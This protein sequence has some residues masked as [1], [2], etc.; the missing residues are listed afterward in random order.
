M[1]GLIEA[2]D[3]STGLSTCLDMRRGGHWPGLKLGIDFL[4]REAAVHST[5]HTYL[6]SRY[7]EDAYLLCV[8]AVSVVASVQTVTG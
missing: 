4:L 2:Q 8:G 3:R 7:Y 1:G 6:L 5:H